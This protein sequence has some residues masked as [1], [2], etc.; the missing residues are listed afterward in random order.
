MTDLPPRDE[1]YGGL[2]A[3]S[4]E[5]WRLLVDSTSNA[6]EPVVQ[7]PKHPALRRTL[8]IAGPV[9]AI[10]IGLWLYLSGGQFVSEDDSY[11]GTSN[12]AITP[13]VTGQVIKVGVMP[14]QIVNEGDLLFEIDPQPFQIALDQARAELE[15]ATEK[16]QG[17]VLT[18]RQQQASVVQATADL[19]FAQQEFD[20]VNA[21]VKDSVETR[22]AFD[23]AQ[24]NLRVAQQAKLAAES[25]A[26]ATLA[27]LGGNIDK[28]LEQ[29][30]VYL[31]AKAQVELA[32]R[33]VR[34]TRILA[35]FAGTV[36]QVENV[37]P[38]TFLSTGQTAFSLIGADS[39]VDANI[40]ETD[41]THIKIG[42]PATV[43]LDS[44]PDVTLHA[45]VQSIS[46]AS[47]SVFALLPAQNASG[48]W[49]KV[50]QRMPVRLRISNPEPEV[51]MRDGASATVS[52]NTGY[53]RTLE[54]LWS[55]LKGMVGI[56]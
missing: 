46:P 56:D 13:Q 18:Y 31:A 1:I 17:L 51:V 43:V 32:E 6:A 8:L 23:Q 36:T 37:Q 50:V 20:R 19:T 11:V 55:D 12:V 38:G 53:H 4:A 22:A 34:L 35:P 33:N 14:N 40:K 42:D 44:Y 27:E 45:V 25:G 39:W 30:A 15:Q 16:L 29:H 26:A 2:H 9:A 21:L 10:G 48:N 7:T 54:T 3:E 41:L 47:G 5:T 28:P 52:I 24:K 49:V